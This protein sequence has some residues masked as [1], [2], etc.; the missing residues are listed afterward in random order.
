ML[1][2]IRGRTMNKMKFPTKIDLV[3][4]QVMMVGRVES[5]KRY[6]QLM[7]TLKS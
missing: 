5:T 6:A 3:F 7:D 1:S 2:R 4:D